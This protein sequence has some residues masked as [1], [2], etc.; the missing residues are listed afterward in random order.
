M[1][2]HRLHG[3]RVPSPGMSLDTNFERLSA[4]QEPEILA[5]SEED[6][7][8][9]PSSGVFKT[10]E[11]AQLQEEELKAEFAAAAAAAAHT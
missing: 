3:R 2:K 11:E 8:L 7:K 1:S 6:L 5:Y 9:E 4:L 10:P